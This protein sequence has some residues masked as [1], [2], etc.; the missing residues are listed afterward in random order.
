MIWANF[1]HIYQPP[2]QKLEILTKV[3]NE[4]YRKI[5]AELKRT[6]RAKVTLNINAVLTEMLVKNGFDDV[7]RDLRDLA[8]AGQVEFTGSAKFHPLLPR[9]PKD[10]VVRQIKLNDET[11]RKYFGEGWQPKGFFPPEMGFSM[12]VAKTVS[13]LG[14][15]WIIADEL[16]YPREYGS[17]GYS[18]TYRIKGLPLKIFFREREISFKILSAQLGTGKL[19]LHELGPRVKENKYLLTAMDGETFGHHRLGLEQLL[20]DLYRSPE[21]ESKLISDLPHLF[22]EEIEITPEPSTWAITAEDI[23]RKIP[24]NRWN[25]PENPIHKMQ[26][27]L[28]DLAIRAVNDSLKPEGWQRAR[29][30]LDQSLHSDQYW[31][32]GAKPWW[33]IEYIERGAKELV[34]A[35]RL[36]PDVKKDI[37]DHAERLYFNIL[38]QAFDW[39]RQGV[40]DRLSKA[41]D[42]EIRRRV[43]INLPS[44]ARR[45]FDRMIVNLKKQ[46]LAAAKNQEYERAAQFRNRIAELNEKKEKIPSQ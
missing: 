19:L 12:D 22:P 38:A 30:A 44:L 3:T 25:D 45:E 4:S 15:Q 42:E 11:N 8:T 27:E 40:V 41:E 14:F 7:V 6:K 17:V 21:I 33:S 18:K 29:E 10:E 32:A 13:E 34:E 2:T 43:D 20:F 26:W 9:I 39:Q 23:E 36:V 16:S 46:M 31:W 37:V 1:L 24:F 5:V 35:I 28:T